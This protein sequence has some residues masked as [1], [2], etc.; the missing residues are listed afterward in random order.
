MHG[1]HHDHIYVRTYVSAIVE[2]ASYASLSLLFKEL[3]GL[4]QQGVFMAV[5][6]GTQ[7]SVQ[8]GERGVACCGRCGML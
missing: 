4:A 2:R 6:A 1:G 5:R 7:R 8:R 3:G